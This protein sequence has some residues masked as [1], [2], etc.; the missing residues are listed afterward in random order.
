[1]L[2]TKLENQTNKKMEAELEI[3]DLLEGV[4]E[5]Y[6]GICCPIMENHVENNGTSKASWEY[7]VYSDR[8]RESIAFLVSM[9]M[10]P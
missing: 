3:P 8:M 5:D 7:M 1:M 2:P 6:L 4:S 10:S 9:H